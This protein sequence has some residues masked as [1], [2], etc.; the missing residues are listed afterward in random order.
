[1]INHSMIE[2]TASEPCRPPSLLRLSVA[3]RVTPRTIA[4]SGPPSTPFLLRQH[5]R[6][7]FRA[8]PPPSPPI[9]LDQSK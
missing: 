9:V 6:I 8:S 1:M 5:T 4:F 3:I 2:R 7:E